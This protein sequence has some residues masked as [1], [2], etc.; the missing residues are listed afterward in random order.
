MDDRGNP[1]EIAEFIPSEIA[2]ASPRNDERGT[3]ARNDIS[4]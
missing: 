2:S 4:V 3:S 1:R